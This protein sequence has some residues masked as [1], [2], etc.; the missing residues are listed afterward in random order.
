VSTVAADSPLARAATAAIQ[1]GDL[2]TLRR[3]LH[4]HPELVTARLGDESEARTLLH[5][6]TDWPGHFPNGPEIVE[7]L[8][9]AGADV[10]ASFV[11]SHAETP[12]HWAASS[13]DIAVLDALLDGGADLEAPGSV[14][15]GGTPIADAVGCGQWQQRAGCSSAARAQRSGKPRR[16]ASPTVSRNASAPVPPR[17]PT[18]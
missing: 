15:G 14:L 18:R 6:A 5:V 2:E 8:I 1:K 7:L 11:G 3:L 9:E 12:L 4:E 17:Q 10:N 13:D 16:S